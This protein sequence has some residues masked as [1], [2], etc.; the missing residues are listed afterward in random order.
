MLLTKQIAVS[1]RANITMAQEDF[2]TVRSWSKE[3]TA[4]TESNWRRLG[5]LKKCV[6][7]GITKLDK[8]S[9]KEQGAFSMACCTMGGMSENSSFLSFCRP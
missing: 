8:M 1:L 7:L 5:A 6:D 3:L 2:A 4:K 9:A